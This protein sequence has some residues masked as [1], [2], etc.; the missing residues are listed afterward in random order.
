MSK[1]HSWA[2]GTSDQYARTQ[3][4]KERGQAA[5]LLVV[6]LMAVFMIVPTVA[7]SQALIEAPP[8]IHVDLLSNAREA[9]QSGLNFFKAAVEQDPLSLKDFPSP[10]GTIENKQDCQTGTSQSGW[11][12]ISKGNSLTSK[13]TEEVLLAAT[14]LPKGASTGVVTVFAEARSG[15]P[16]HWTC[17]E[18]K[19]RIDVTGPVLNGPAPGHWASY[20]L[21]PW[22]KYA[23]ASLAGAEG[24]GCNLVNTTSP[25]PCAY[26]S[27]HQL[28]QAG[29]GAEFFVALRLPKGP[30]VIGIGVGAHLPVNQSIPTGQSP[31]QDPGKFAHGGESGWTPPQDSGFVGWL[32]KELGGQDP[33]ASFP[34]GGATVVLWCKAL[35]NDTNPTCDPNTP[36]AQVLAVAGGGGGSGSDGTSLSLLKSTIYLGGSGGNGGVNFPVALPPAGNWTACNSPGGCAAAGEPGS[37]GGG[38]PL[39]GPSGGAGGGGGLTPNPT[40]TLASSLDGQPANPVTKACDINISLFGLSFGNASIPYSGGGGGG[41][42]AGGNQGSPGHRG[43]LNLFCD[44]ISGSGGGGGGSSYIKKGSYLMV[45]DSGNGSLELAKPN[46]GTQGFAQLWLSNSAP[47]PQ[48]APNSSC[49]PPNKLLAPSPRAQDVAVLLKG[50]SGYTNN[51]A[52]GGAGAV[53]PV[54]IQLPPDAYLVSSCVSGGSGG[55]GSTLTPTPSGQGGAGTALCYSQSLTPCLASSTTVLAVAG[56]GGGTGDQGGAGASAKGCFG[57]CLSGNIGPISTFFHAGQGGNAGMPLGPPGLDTSYSTSNPQDTYP[58]LQPGRSGSSG[59]ISATSSGQLCVPSF[60]GISGPCFSISVSTQSGGVGGSSVSGAG[61][62]P[63]ISAS[64]ASGC[65]VFEYSG[66]SYELG[67]GGGGGGGGWGGGQAGTSGGSYCSSGGG[68]ST[69]IFGSYGLAW[70][71]GWGIPGGGGGGGSSWEG[72]ALGTGIGWWNPAPSPGQV[73][74]GKTLNSSGGAV[75]LGSWPAETLTGLSVI[76]SAPVGS[77]SWS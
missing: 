64:T 61:P 57:G 18:E 72:G 33:T 2:V 42:Y 21:P 39:I 46:P 19:M 32:A 13:P 60:F 73:A 1:V 63:G 25:A 70:I 77:T 23:Y 51:D 35:P 43:F 66:P 44:S 28:P 47:S 30:G 5:I 59:N 75:V 16:G 10:Q 29:K 69:G 22:A 38:I 67:G 53:F 36:G 62:E 37:S 55:D 76:S 54:L 26:S 6:A 71:Y 58:S 40:S 7:V 48:S 9:A 74:T 34:G 56:A 20:P 8:M 31:A 68:I 45:M 65:P 11:Q 12:V 4:S 3:S 52:P 17:D 14:K 24:E 15:I 27:N 49:K 41:G 50:Q